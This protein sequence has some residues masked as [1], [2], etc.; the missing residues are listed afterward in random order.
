MPEEVDGLTV[1]ALYNLS[2]QMRMSVD[3]VGVTYGGDRGKKYLF[4]GFACSAA[5]QLDAKNDQN[6]TTSAF[7]KAHH[8]E[9]EQLSVCRPGTWVGCVGQGARM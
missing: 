8:S 3:Q 2:S 4:W 9:A 5:T 7:G 1:L 6:L